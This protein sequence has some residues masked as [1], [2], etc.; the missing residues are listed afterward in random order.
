MYNMGA[1]DTSKG[2]GIMITLL[3]LFNRIFVAS[4]CNKYRVCCQ[5]RGGQRSLDI[6]Y[7]LTSGRRTFLSNRAYSDERTW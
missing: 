3:A 2:N 5:Q 4:H 1:H 7:K 6:V